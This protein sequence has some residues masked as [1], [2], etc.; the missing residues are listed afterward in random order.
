MRVEQVPIGDI[1]VEG[2]FRKELGDLKGLAGS[3]QELGGA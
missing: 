2:R 1:V 3:I